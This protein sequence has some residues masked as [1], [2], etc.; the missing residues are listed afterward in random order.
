MQL[1]GDV[2]TKVAQHHFWL[3]FQWPVM[4]RGQGVHMFFLRPQIFVVNYSSKTTLGDHLSRI[5]PLLHRW[6]ML[7]Q[8]LI[9]DGKL[10]SIHV[11][12]K[13]VRWTEEIRTDRYVTVL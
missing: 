2:S 1:F 10:D 13:Y 4:G 6:T 11:E 7:K 3:N 8:W 12:E 9:G 5:Q